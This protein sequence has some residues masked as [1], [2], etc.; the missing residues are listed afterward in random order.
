MSKI[1]GPLKIDTD[2]DDYH[3]TFNWVA[4]P[5]SNLDLEDR[6]KDMIV[7]GGITDDDASYSYDYWALVLLDGRYYSFSTSGCSCPSPSETC[8]IEIGRSTLDGI[9]KHIESGDYSGY[10]LPK[11]QYS[12][13][14]EV[15]EHARSLEKKVKP[16]ALP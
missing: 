10:T 8:R 14:M 3:N 9:Q 4:H 11:K 15:I 7:L 2:S 5:A 6:R 1:L 13:F 16:R 12:Q